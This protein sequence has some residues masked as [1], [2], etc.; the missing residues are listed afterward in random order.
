MYINLKLAKAKDIH[1][2]KIISL[3]LLKQA[4]TSDVS[5]DL[6]NYCGAVGL[7][8]LIEQGYA[9]CLKSKKNTTLFHLARLSKKGKELLEM[10]ETPDIEEG[11]IN[12][13]D[14]L[15]KMYFSDDAEDRKIGNKKATLM[16]IS[17]FRQIMGFTLHEMYYLCS[18][19]CAEEKFTK[20]MEYIFFQKKD[21]PYG[22]FKD[23]IE[24]SKL[25]IFYE[26]NKDRI[27]KYWEQVI[28]E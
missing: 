21:N 7:Q 11:D 17:Q 23:N 15:V 10:L 28:K 5:G 22:K 16:Y 27:H 9:E 6:E 26:T 24:S 1:L 4:K 3:Q 18:L 14:Y 25:H 13:M 19:F 12:M 2:S 8:Q 20:V